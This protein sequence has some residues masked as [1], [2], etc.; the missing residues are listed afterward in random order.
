MKTTF[1]EIIEIVLEHEGGYVTIQMMLE[2]KPNMESLKDGILMWT[3][4]I[5]QKNKLKNI[6]YRLLET[7]V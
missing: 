4:K 1:D 5:L 7:W 3:L 6:S 2:V